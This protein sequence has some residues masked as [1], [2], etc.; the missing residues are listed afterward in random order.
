MLGLLYIYSIYNIYLTTYSSI[1]IYI[2][3]SLAVAKVGSHARFSSTRGRGDL[4]QCKLAVLL[5]LRMTKQLPTQEGGVAS[6]SLERLSAV[7]PLFTQSGHD[8]HQFWGLTALPPLTSR[9]EAGPE[10]EKAGG[11][12]KVAALTTNRL[13]PLRGGFSVA[14]KDG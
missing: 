1:Y 4:E 2:A 5:L 7:C 10:A 3:R 14:A 6:G 9:L 11:L 8:R 12:C 13:N